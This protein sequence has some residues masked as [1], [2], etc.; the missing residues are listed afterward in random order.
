MGIA[1]IIAEYNPFYSG[2]LYQIKE[3]RKKLGEETQILALMSGDFVQ[4]GEPAVMDKYLRTELAL[5]GGVS[6]VAELPVWMA[7]ASAADFAEGAVR[8][9]NAL[10]C[11]DYLCFGCEHDNLELL[12]ETAG[13]FLEEPEPYRSLLKGDLAG[14]QS[15][16][17]AR[18]AAFLQHLK[19]TGASF[20][21]E[22]SDHG[23]LRLPNNILAISYLIALRKTGS[24]IQPLPLRR[25]GNY[26]SE[27]ASLKA[28]G[29]EIISPGSYMD[30]GE[31][32][33]Y[34]GATAIRRELMR[35]RKSGQSAWDLP[36]ALLTSPGAKGLLLEQ[37]GKSFP[38]A[39]ED[40]FPALKYTLS[41]RA[42]EFSVYA[43][44]SEE[45]A[46]RLEKGWLE[47]MSMEELA[48]YLHTANYTRSRACRALLHIL[49]GIRQDEVQ[50]WKENGWAFYLRIL[51]FLKQDETLIRTLASSSDIP[52][53]LR[54]KLSEEMEDALSPAALTSYRCDIDAADRYEL[55]RTMIPGFSARPVREYSKGLIKI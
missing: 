46:N 15:F 7:T 26:H 42:K 27:P 14:G 49:L 19:E 21:H 23:F 50:R 6:A 11:V 38:V 29:A 3:L 52:L 18:E 41:M 4:R 22:E 24:S 35:E 51:G 10:G 32:V 30:A 44:V 31:D 39:A 20:Y 53:L 54:A 25:L 28:A 36:E 47:Q 5:R 40:F 34:P 9:L 12:Q 45:M 43:D 48:D 33:R 17:A 13:I 2:H 8:I 55:L 16:P 1:A 37:A